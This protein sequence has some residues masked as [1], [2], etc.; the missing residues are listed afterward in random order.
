MPK[1]LSVLVAAVGV[2]LAVI[3]TVSGFRTSSAQFSASTSNRA[4]LWEAAEVSMDVGVERTGRAD[5]FLDASGLH[6][7]S[8]VQNCVMVNI[9]ASTSE[10]RVRIHGAMV[11]DEGLAEFF[12]VVIEQGAAGGSCERFVA[13]T[14][15]YRGTLNRLATTNGSFERGAPVLD[16]SSVP[17]PFRF[18]GWIQ[19]NNSAQGK[20]LEYMVY[21]EAKP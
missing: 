21:L 3:V 4:N 12:D 1:H 8:E 19:D 6:T 9:D 7:G 5:L 18:T 11:A 15:V 10:F 14:E 13:E 2:G 20:A 17:T 16:L